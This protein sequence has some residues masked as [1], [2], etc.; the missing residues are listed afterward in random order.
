MGTD[1]ENGDN[2]SQYSV[3]LE[4]TITSVYFTFPPRLIFSRKLDQ[5]ALVDLRVSIYV[6]V[7]TQ[8]R[9]RNETV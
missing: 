5:L 1:T 9:S 6:H 2:T 4:V 7:T 8:P 3:K